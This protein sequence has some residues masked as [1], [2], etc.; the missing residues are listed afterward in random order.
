MGSAK[1]LLP[2]RGGTLVEYHVAELTGAGVQDIVVVL[3]HDADVLRPRVPAPARVV[4]N[5]AYR[6]GRASSLRAGAAALPDDA[7][8]IVVLGVDQPRPRELVRRLLDKQ[9][10]NGPA[11]TVPVS[12]GRRGHP[13]VLS[14]ALLPELRQATEEAQGL[15]GVIAAHEGDIHE[16]HFMMSVH[17]SVPGL[18]FTALIVLTDMNTP[19][20]YEQALGLFGK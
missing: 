7:G 2:W 14:A 20:D 4:V 10:E 12:D 19:E 1:A 8:P 18:D 6:E 3:G 5:G 11:V 17:E 9:K 15:R 16:V 13:T